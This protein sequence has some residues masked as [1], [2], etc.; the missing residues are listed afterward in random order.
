LEDAPGGALVPGCSVTV[1]PKDVLSGVVD[2][3][4]ASL[5]DPPAAK[6]L[7][8]WA[9]DTPATTNKRITRVVRTTARYMDGPCLFG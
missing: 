6:N 7:L 2:P 3:G 8:S 5:C 4:G 1:A 9:T